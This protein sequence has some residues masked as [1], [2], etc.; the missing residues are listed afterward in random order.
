[1][2]ATAVVVNL[3]YF[4]YSAVLAPYFSRLSRPWRVVLSYIT[5]D[6]MFALFVGRYSKDDL[7]PHKHWYYL[8]GSLLMWSTWQ[9]ASIA[10]IFGGTLI[11]REWA[12]EFAA[13]LALTA[14]L[15][16]LLYDRSVTFGA[17][18]AGVVAIL[19]TRLPMNLGVVVAVGTGVAAGLLTSRLASGRIGEETG[20]VA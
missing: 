17:V 14:L 20:D 13:T 18:T 15:I 8:G 10:G 1:M 4:I 3:R 5:V 7:F 9:L 2:Y 6:G 16:P 19:A 12:L 11:P